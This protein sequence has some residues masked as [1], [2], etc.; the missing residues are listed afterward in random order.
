MES[1]LKVDIE[2]MSTFSDMNMIFVTLN[3][4]HVNHL[5]I[6][7]IMQESGLADVISEDDVPLYVL[8]MYSLL[9]TNQ[10]ARVFQ[11]APS[12][13]RLCIVATNVAETSLTI[14]GIKYVVDTGRVSI[15]LQFI[16]PYSLL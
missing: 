9:A 11:P 12:D 6:I 5:C 4:M 1:L 7:F 2:K 8:P 3:N 10:Q 15:L 13:T 16:I 14:P